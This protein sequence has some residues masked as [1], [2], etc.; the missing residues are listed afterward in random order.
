MFTKHYQNIVLKEKIT[1]QNIFLIILE[2][3][4]VIRSY[5]VHIIVEN[6]LVSINIM[7]TP[8]NRI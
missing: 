4:Y 5:Y 7:S 2:N 6:R 3:T 1:F 8:L